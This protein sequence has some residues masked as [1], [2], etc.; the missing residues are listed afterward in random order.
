M[1][2]SELKDKVVIVA[3]ARTAVGRFDGMYRDLSTADLGSAAAREAIERSGVDAESV[4]E[5]IMGCIGQVGPE[6]Y[7]ARRVAL[8]AGLPQKTTAFNVNRLCGSGLQ[9]IFSAAQSLAFNASQVVVA[10]GN[11]SMTNMPYLDY[12][13]GSRR[14]LAPKKLEHGTLAMLTDPFSNSH[15]GNTADNVSA[16]FKVS[17]ADQDEFALR[18]QQLANLDSSRAAFAQEIVSGSLLDSEQ[19]DRDEHPRDSV[20]LESLAALK[21]AFSP[22]GSATAGNSSGINDGAAAMVLAKQSYVQA[23]GLPA[24]ATV[25]HVVV[26]AMD[27]SLMGY[28]PTYALEKLFAETGL[29]A[30]DID[31]FE[32]NE[33]FAA[34]ALAVIRDSGLDPE[35]VNP[36][37]GA[38]AL[39]HPVGATGAILTLRAAMDLHRRDKELAVITLCIG[40]GQAI[41]ALIKRI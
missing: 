8:G 29:G 35:R 10:G 2:M 39:G 37:G 24:L 34:Q 21:P 14:T 28:A 36:Y 22:N 31:V 7:N 25:E 1:G 15:M 23:H 17:R 3:G 27:P 9:A 6:S 12:S 4:D 13:A 11:E 30:S 20:T 26:T 38:I 41:A 40:G 5:V 32:L 16:K 19:Q 18:S 33:A